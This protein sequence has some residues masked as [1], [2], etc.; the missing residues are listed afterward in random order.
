MVSG[1]CFRQRVSYLVHRRIHTGAMPY[2]CTA[3]GKS[4]RYKVSQRTHKCLSQPPGTIVRQSGDLVQKLLQ[5]VQQRAAPAS[6]QMPATH[7][8][9]SSGDSG[10]TVEMKQRLTAQKISGDSHHFPVPQQENQHQQFNNSQFTI[11][12]GSEV[13]SVFPPGQI[14]LASN[15]VYDAPSLNTHVMCSV[16]GENSEMEQKS[17][18]QKMREGIEVLNNKINIQSSKKPAV[19]EVTMATA[20]LKDKQEIQEGAYMVQD[21][22]INL[23]VG[24]MRNT[25]DCNVKVSSLNAESSQEELS[26]KKTSNKNNMLSTGKK[27]AQDSVFLEASEF[28]ISAKDELEI[29]TCSSANFWKSSDKIYKEIENS[30]LAV[31]TTDFFTMVTSPSVKRLP[32]PSEKLKHLT[33]SSP[34]DT[35][36]GYEDDV[37]YHYLLSSS[38]MVVQTNQEKRT[39]SSSSESSASSTK[40][41]QCEEHGTRPLQTINEESLKHLLYG[42]RGETPTLLGPWTTPVRLAASKAP[43]AGNRSNFQ[44][45]AFSSF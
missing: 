11:I 23:N 27:L 22:G 44:N 38:D 16:S 1:K 25:T 43:E 37:M 45:V 8:S 5:G 12:V 4:F 13:S 15:D 32:S 30:D 42:A 17:D 21:D 29:S 40:T 19:V 39:D 2:Q 10:E 33:L 14:L 28:H 35:L 3:C 31:E 24:N 26:F 18:T 9:L 41:T 7:M 36:L 20:D 34:V 6:S